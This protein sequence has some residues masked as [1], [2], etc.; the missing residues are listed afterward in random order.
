MYLYSMII[1]T[2]A[3]YIGNKNKPLT[4]NMKNSIKHNILYI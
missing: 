1:Y 4:Y 2:Y 3:E